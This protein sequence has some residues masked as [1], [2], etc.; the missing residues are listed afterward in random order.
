MR[1][2]KVISIFK[3]ADFKWFCFDTFNKR[4]IILIFI[5]INISGQLKQLIRHSTWIARNINVDFWY[6]YRIEIKAGFADAEVTLYINANIGNQVRLGTRL[7]LGGTHSWKAFLILFC[8]CTTPFL[9]FRQRK[10]LEQWM[11]MYIWMHWFA[12][13][14]FILRNKNSQI[15]NNSIPFLFVI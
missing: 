7:S 5:G 12:N 4:V 6:F 9:F 10:T 13:N 2:V 11:L 14:L 8:T 3:F 15:S 1:E